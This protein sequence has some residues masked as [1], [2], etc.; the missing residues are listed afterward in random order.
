MITRA[1]RFMVGHGDERATLFPARGFLR[2]TE[3][4]ALGN[5]ARR[6]S[7]RRP[8]IRLTQKCAGHVQTVNGNWTDASSVRQRYQGED[9]LTAA[10]PPFPTRSHLSATEGPHEYY[11]LSTNARAGRRTISTAVLQGAHANRK[12][13]GR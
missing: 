11:S 13:Y 4:A 9:P 7:D 12:A 2:Q 3:R 1:P 6:W 5:K 10:A 8:H